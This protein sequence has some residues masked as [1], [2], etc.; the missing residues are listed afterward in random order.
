[1]VY[2]QLRKSLGAKVKGFTTSQ[3]S[4]NDVIEKLKL[5]FEDQK[6]FLPPETVW[7]DLHLELATFGYKVLPSGKLSYSAPSGM[8]DDIVMSLAFAN[9]ALQE[10]KVKS[11][12]FYGS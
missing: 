4:K 7:P 3:N 12:Y 1:V 6:I 10:S 11:V 5:A 8:T 9:H 2:E